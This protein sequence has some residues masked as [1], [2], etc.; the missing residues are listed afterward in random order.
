MKKI[1]FVIPTM[2]MGGAERSLVSLLNALDPERVAVDLL[3]FEA[4]GVLQKDIPEWVHV[5]EA[6][7]ITRGMTLELRKYLP[8]LAR[9]SIAAAVSRIWMSERAVFKRRLHLPPSFSWNTI[10]KYLPK[11]PG[12]YETA[13]GFLEGF[14]DFYVID[15]VSADRK[16]GWIHT[17]MSAR[18]YLSEEAQYYKIFDGIG[19]ISEQCLHAFSSLYSEA[20]KRATVIPNVVLPD[21]VKRKADEAGCAP[22]SEF[23]GDFHHLI[24][25]G[26]L[27]EAK[28]IDV[29]IEVCYL[30]KERGLPVIWHVYGEGELREQLEKQISEY[31]MEGTFILEGLTDNPYPYMKAADVVVQPSRWEGKSL[32]LSEAKILGKAIVVTNYSSVR[33]QIQDG[34][35]G[36]VVGME[37]GLIADAIERVITD[38]DLRETLENNCRKETG[39]YEENLNAFYRLIDA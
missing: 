17:N 29:A 31:N 14:T 30:L 9:K 8:E 10:K 36:L 33:D 13:I 20:G 12:H 16:I 22:W 24:T 23:G 1:L 4:G 18:Q 3:L 15:K 35:T 5:I 26:R 6:D 39:N 21:E 37:P 27:S 19:V 11:L 28:G 32:V 38:R 25:V 34:Q 7:P 2:R